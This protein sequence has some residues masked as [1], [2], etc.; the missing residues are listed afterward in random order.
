M[1]VVQRQSWQW[2]KLNSQWP[3]TWMLGVRG[4]GSYGTLSR[5]CPTLLVQ[6]KTT[7]WSKQG[8]LERTHLGWIYTVALH[9]QFKFLPISNI[10]TATL[11]VASSCRPSGVMT[12][13]V[14]SDVT[15]LWVLF[16]SLFL[17]CDI[18]WFGDIWWYS[19]Q[20]ISSSL[21]PLKLLG[22]SNSVSVVPVYI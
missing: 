7:V 9:A 14:S 8:H 6:F 5:L 17:T 10:L 12:F 20:W 3:I 22:P 1:K 2:G 16:L 19:C 11:L 18:W 15:S 4:A 13:T 21:L